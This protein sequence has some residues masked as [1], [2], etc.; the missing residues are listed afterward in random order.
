MESYVRIVNRN[1]EEPFIGKYDG[2]YLTIP[3]G[4][5]KI[6]PEDVMFVWMGNPALENDGRT[7]ERR[8]VYFRLASLYHARTL[9][10]IDVDAFPMLEAYTEDGERIITVL[11]D[12]EGDSL[13][14]D[15]SDNTDIG[16]L[17]RQIERLEARLAERLNGL[18]DTPDGPI[19]EPEIGGRS[20]GTEG[21]I[22]AEIAEERAIELGEEPVTV[23]GGDDLGIP[24][25]E[26]TKTPVGRSRAKKAPAK[27]SGRARGTAGTA[28]RRAAAK[29]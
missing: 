3:A 22:N 14:P 4:G 2:D 18:V 20:A 29:K 10:G 19:D 26:P 15:S 13:V 6:V 8:E 23:D 17:Q 25:D 16:K 12:P 9:T 27:P 7:N 11:D 28:G 24:V 5:E 1:P 21:E